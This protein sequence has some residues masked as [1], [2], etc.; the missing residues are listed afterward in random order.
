[1][2]GR[3]ISIEGGEGVGKSTQISRLAH[4]L[5]SNGKQIVVTREPGGTLG[6]EAVRALLLSPKG[7]GWGARAEALL[8]AAARSDHVEKLIEPTLAAGK[9]VLSDRF[10]D[11]SRAYQGGASD[12]GDT[13][14]MALHEIGSHGL[15]PDITILLAMPSMQGIE[16]AAVRDRGE[17]DRIGGRS[18]GYHDGVAATFAALASKDPKRIKVV[19]ASGSVEQVHERVV[20][21]I[22]PLL[23]ESA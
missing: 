17:T 12:L 16:R 19:D 3:F 8:F 5:V 9:W 13:A 10:I 18:S 11:S 6:A 15:L 22:A 14:I 21:V 1:M 2:R 7:D 20:A 4:Y 23:K